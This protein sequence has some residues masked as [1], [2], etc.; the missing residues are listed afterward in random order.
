MSNFR[1]LQ[2]VR[3]VQ[4]LIKGEAPWS[5]HAREEEFYPILDLV[6]QKALAD[7]SV[8]AYASLL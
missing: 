1:L 6:T 3:F 8:E 5:Y 2:L 4:L 7:P